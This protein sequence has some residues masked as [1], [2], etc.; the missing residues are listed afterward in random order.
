[1]PTNKEQLWQ[2]LE[3]EWYNFPMESLQKLY[4]SMPRRITALVKAKGGATKY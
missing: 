4:E 2:A 1:L 3:E